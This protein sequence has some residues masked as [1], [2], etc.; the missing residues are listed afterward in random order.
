MLTVQ[1]GIEHAHKV[2]KWNLCLTRSTLCFERLKLLIEIGM[3][4]AHYGGFV[5][6]KVNVNGFQCITHETY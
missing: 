6:G 3:Y 2:D 4:I 1:V 5:T